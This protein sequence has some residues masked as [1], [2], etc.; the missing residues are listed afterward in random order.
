LSVYPFDVLAMAE[1]APFDRTLLDQRPFVQHA[2]RSP[3]QGTPHAREAPNY[4]PSR[5]LRTS[6]NTAIALGQPLLLTGPPGHGKTQAAYWVAWKLQ[7]GPVLEFP[8][9]STS[10]SRDLIYEFEAVR[11]MAEALREKDKPPPPRG[12]F[13]IRRP[14]WDAFAADHPRVLLIDEIDK[15]PRDFPND[16]L[17]EFD[18]WA[19]DIQESGQRITAPAERRPIVII[20]SNGERPLPDP[21][22]RRCIF[23]HIELDEEEIRSILRARRDAGDFP[24]SN[25]LIDGLLEARRRWHGSVEREP[26]IAELLSWLGMMGIK[27]VDVIDQSQ[28]LP[29]R[30][31]L[32]KTQGDQDPGE[33]L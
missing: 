2:L 33:K 22:L 14:L 6:I 31:V 28:P 19:F 17:Y 26:G 7:L 8:V 30:E 3:I 10:T 1:Q 32:F 13:V 16:L 25:T 12:D 5:S 4:Q 29:N 18:Q 21:F 24:A 23:H 11:Y 20:T 15:A 9:K 27:G